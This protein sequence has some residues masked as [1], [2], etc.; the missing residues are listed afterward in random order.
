MTLKQLGE[1]DC[2]SYYKNYLKGLDPDLD[3]KALLGNQLQNFP[4]FLSSIPESKLNFSYG[5]GKWTLV[6]SLVHVFD[7]ERVF[8]YRALRFGRKDMTPLPGFDQDLWVPQSKAL[9]RTIEDIIEEYR[10][11]RL[12]T[13]SLFKQFTDQDFEFRGISSGQEITLGASGFIIC[14]HQRHHR[15]VIKSNYL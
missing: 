4:K 3:L 7:T 12:S 11:I 1:N 6:E 15:E 10:A 14:G 13:I 8:Q 5:P 9:N 2:P